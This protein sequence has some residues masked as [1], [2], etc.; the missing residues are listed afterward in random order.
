MLFEIIYQWRNSCILKYKQS[1][2]LTIE[3]DAECTNLIGS[4][5][6]QCEIQYQTLPVRAFLYRCAADCAESGIIA[7]DILYVFYDFTLQCWCKWVKYSVP[8]DASKVRIHQLFAFAYVEIVEKILDNQIIICQA[9]WTKIS[10]YCAKSAIKCHTIFT[11]NIAAHQH[12][13][14]RHLEEWSLHRQLWHYLNQHLLLH[15]L[16]RQMIPNYQYHWQRHQHL[17]QYYLLMHRY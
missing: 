6:L 12:P 8:D 7:D 17:Q 15:R 11:L 5:K 16:L 14:L 13:W 9:I 10:V 1:I 2:E 3:S 4:C